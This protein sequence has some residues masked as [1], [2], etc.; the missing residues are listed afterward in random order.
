MHC[1]KINYFIHYT[2]P[3]LDLTLF[4]AL[5]ELHPIFRVARSYA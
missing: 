3:L 2:Y 1:H 5:R 4:I